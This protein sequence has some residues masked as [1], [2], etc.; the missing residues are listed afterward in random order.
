MIECQL[1]DILPIKVENLVLFEYGANQELALWHVQIGMDT[2]SVYHL[3]NN[4]ICY[5]LYMHIYID[6]I[7]REVQDNQQVLVH[8]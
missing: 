5:L 4:L 6:D 7:L 2:L 1:E 8:D 3:I